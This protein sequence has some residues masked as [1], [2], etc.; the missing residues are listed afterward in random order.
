MKSKRAEFW[1]G[2][3]LP[4]A[5]NQRIVQRKIIMQWV[6]LLVEVQGE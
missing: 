2:E 3:V 6:S 4:Q 1:K 5:N